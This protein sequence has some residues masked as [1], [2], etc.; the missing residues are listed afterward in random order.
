MRAVAV[1]SVCLGVLLFSGRA[2]A[3]TERPEWLVRLESWSRAVDSH[4]PGARD[5]AVIELAAWAHDDV[6]H[7]VTDYQALRTVMRRVSKKGPRRLRPVFGIEYKESR[8]T[9]E[10]LLHL[11]VFQA[12]APAELNRTLRRAAMLHADVALLAALDL[13]RSSGPPDSA[14]VLDGVIVGYEGQSAHWVVGRTLLDGITPSPAADGFVRL[15]YRAAA[16]AFLENG[17]L[18]GAKPH[19]EHALDVLP[20]DPDIRYEA[21]CYH[22]ASA[23]PA[24]AAVIRMQAKTQL[25][26][27][28]GRHYGLDRGE[29]SEHHRTH[30]RRE[31]ERALGLDANH[32]EARLRLGWQLLEDNRLDE[33]AGHLERA[34]D[35]S[36]DPTLSYLSLMLLGQ[37]TERSEQPEVADRHYARAANLFPDAPSPTFARAALARAAGRREAAWQ[38]VTERA[39]AQPDTMGVDPWWTFFRWRLRPSAVLIEELRDMSRADVLR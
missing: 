32:T 34:A 2:A 25:Y 20:K 3:Q 6:Q 11:A 36:A 33:A 16:A 22:Q 35:A 14:K 17:N 9:T 12:E 26:S 31:F 27:G 23:A 21:G 18:A 24:I 38:L 10:D 39:Q 28:L 8:I 19:L 1:A 5:D 13:S 30:A 15:W 4:Q 29:S 7:V 37:A